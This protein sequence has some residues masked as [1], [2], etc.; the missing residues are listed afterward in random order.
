VAALG[1][2]GILGIGT[3]IQD[4]GKNCAGGQTF[5]GYPYY[6]CPNNLCQ[7]EPVPIEQQVSNPVAF[8]AQDNNGVEILLP[9]ISSAGAPSL[10]Y[11]N[12]DGTGLIP[13]GLLIFGVGTESNNALGSA[14]VYATDEYGNFPEIVYN[15]FSYLSDGFLDTGSNA[16]YVSDAQTLG[17]QDCADNPYYCPETPLS[18]SLTTYGANGTSGAVTLNIANADTLFGTN[19]GFAAFNNLGGP[20]G[21]GL[22]TDYFDL[23]L[24]FFFGMKNGVFV[25]IAGTTAPKNVSAPNGY[26]AF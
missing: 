2:N 15:G 3:S 16:L 21:M 13:A 11:T 17:I 12:A 8:F 20:S 23:G 25:G 7:T 6:I 1:A 22:S 24:P 18:L 26:F 19:P 14:T 9:A 10:P 4:C 5:S